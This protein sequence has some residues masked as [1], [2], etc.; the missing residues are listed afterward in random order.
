VNTV[1]THVGE[2]TRR[3]E[4]PRKSLEGVDRVVK[5]LRMLE[6]DEPLTLADV[7]RRSELS[8]PTTLRYLSSLCLHGLV[9]V[10]HGVGRV[11]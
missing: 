8:Q 3:D 10:E 7:A 5:V 4:T 2:S 6:S 9:E 1:S 11:Q